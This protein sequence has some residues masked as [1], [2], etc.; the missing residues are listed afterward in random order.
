MIEHTAENDAAVC[1]SCGRPIVERYSG[2]F[3]KAPEPMPMMWVHD[4]I[5][6]PRYCGWAEP[7]TRPIPPGLG[8]L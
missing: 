6:Y 2:T 1:A 3:F 5:G 7:A 8:A 4:E